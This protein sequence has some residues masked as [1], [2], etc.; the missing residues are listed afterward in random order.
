M[1]VIFDNGYGCGYSS[2]RPH[3][4]PISYIKIDD[5]DQKPSKSYIFQIHE[6]GECLKFDTQSANMLVSMKICLINKL[7]AR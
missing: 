1:S 7:R 4:I 3:A 5:K 2:T 6:G